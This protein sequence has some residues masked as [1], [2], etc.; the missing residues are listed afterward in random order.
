MK[1]GDEQ[2]PL[3]DEALEQTNETLAAIGQT[4]IGGETQGK[5]WLLGREPGTEDFEN[6]GDL[7]VY[8]R[9]TYFDRGMQAGVEDRPRMELRAGAVAEFLRSHG[10]SMTSGSYS[11]LEQGRSL[12]R[13][14]D[15]FLELAAYCL[16]VPAT[17]KYHELLRAQYIYDHT[18]NTL[19]QEIADLTVRTGARLLD[20]LRET[21]ANRNS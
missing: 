4:A 1:Q 17:S 8:L 11:F 15:H 5:E 9:Q 18:R 7:L 19:G 10:Y 21:H 16:N 13:V 12:P 14:P 3:T 6:L 2:F 20:Y